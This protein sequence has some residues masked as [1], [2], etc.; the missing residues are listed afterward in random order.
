MNLYNYLKETEVLNDIK[1]S[2]KSPIQ[3]AN[4]LIGEYVLIIKEED[5]GRYLDDIEE[6]LNFIVKILEGF[7]YN[8]QPE[9]IPDEPEEVF[10]NILNK[11]KDE[12]IVFYNNLSKDILNSFNSQTRYIIN[13]IEI[14][15]TNF[16]DEGE[17]LI[18]TDI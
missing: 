15:R 18:D 4:R 10:K 5:R 17:V 8:Y 2:L 13:L 14:H 6:Q 16:I 11:Y 7:G 1:Q 9:Q 12:L 3:K